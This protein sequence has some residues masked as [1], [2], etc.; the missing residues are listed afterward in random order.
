MGAAGNRAHTSSFGRFAAIIE[1]V[2]TPLDVAELALR[3]AGAADQELDD[4]VTSTLAQLAEHAAAERTYVTLY[5]DDDT[6]EVSHEWTI[7]GTVPHKPVIQRLRSSEFAYSYEMAK[8]D[9][10]LNA[11]DLMSLPVEAAA[12][13]RSFSAFG[14]EAILQVPIIVSGE[15]VG[16]IGFNNYRGRPSWP[17]D[18]IEFAHSIAP[19]LGVALVRQR[20]A[21]AVR[22]AYEAAERANLAKDELLEQVSHD[23]RT[24]LHA[25][26][27]YAELLEL[28]VQS[29]VDRDALTQ[30][31]FNGRR[32]LSMV[33]GLLLLGEQPDDDVDQPASLAS[34][35]HAALEQLEPVAKQ[36]EIA[37]NVRGELSSD[38]IVD[39]P[40]RL[41]QVVYCSISGVIQAIGLGGS[42]DVGPVEEG[43]GIHLVVRSESAF[44]DT[45]MGTPLARALLEGH[46]TIDQT[47]S[48][49]RAATVTIA[50][51][52]Q[53]ASP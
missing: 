43:H 29:D 22:R 35:V 46:G 5:H 48:G 36:R 38:A 39:G 28:D 15:C 31:Q 40:A 27:G 50:V 23:L 32:L 24:P 6:F 21:R 42:V 41:G 2:S 44:R 33:E 47:R 16:L 49:D 45:T 4:V 8:R 26:L 37:I 7:E 30:I 13:K 9:E 18:V 20:S 11:P 52:G 3:L 25:I 53:L 14:V 19:A 34:A 1:S 51:D 10:V 12:E 17:V